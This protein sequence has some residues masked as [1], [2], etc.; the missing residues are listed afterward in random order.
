MSIGDMDD[1]SSLVILVSAFVSV[2]HYIAD[3]GGTL[4]CN[5]YL[6]KGDRYGVEDAILVKDPKVRV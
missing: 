2:H 3:L 1:R 4:S 5:L 6:T